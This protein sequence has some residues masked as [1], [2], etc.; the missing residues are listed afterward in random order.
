[1]AC[2]SPPPPHGGRLAP[3]C[4]CGATPAASTA[5]LQN[6]I[7]IRLSLDAPAFTEGAPA[8]LRSSTL[9]PSTSSTSSVQFGCNRRRAFSS[10]AVAA[11]PSPSSSTFKPSSKSSKSKKGGGGRGGPSCPNW[12]PL[13]TPFVWAGTEADALDASASPAAFASLPPSWKVLLLS[14]GSVT[15]HLHILTGRPV[16]VDL[17]EMGRIA[18]GGGGGSD[19]ENDENEEDQETNYSLDLP[20]GAEL[21]KGPLVQRRVLLRADEGKGEALVYAASWWNAADAAATLDGETPAPSSS[22]SR[23]PSSSPVSSRRE[24]PVWTSLASSRTELFREI[25]S[26]YLGG[27]PALERDLGAEPGQEL[28][29][30]HYLFWNGGKPLTVIYEVFSPRLGEWLGGRGGGGLRT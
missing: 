13:S 23:S 1:M 2:P 9:S 28:W 3:R 16:A 12:H 29:G 26:V 19:D 14:D 22:S 25:R 4:C 6:G 20:S 11:S 21:L 15:R 10:L 18:G 8:R 7:N 5:W 30:R 17:L 24:Q 27:C